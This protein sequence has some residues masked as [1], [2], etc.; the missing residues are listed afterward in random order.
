MLSGS[1]EKT[2]VSLEPQQAGPLLERG[3]QW[4]PQRAVAEEESLLCGAPTPAQRTGI[5]AGVY[6]IHLFF[7]LQF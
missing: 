6:F 3:G 5:H 2:Q 4:G 1:E 7:L